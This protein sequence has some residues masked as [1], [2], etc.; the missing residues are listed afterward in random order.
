MLWAK[1][2]TTP[3]IQTLKLGRWQLI[4]HLDS[5]EPNWADFPRRPRNCSPRPSSSLSWDTKV[6]RSRVKGNKIIR[7][8]CP[9]NRKQPCHRCYHTPMAHL[10]LRVLWW[11]FQNRGDEAG[12]FFPFGNEIITN[13]SYEMA[14]HII[15]LS[16]ICLK[17]RWNRKRIVSISNHK[18]Q[19]YK[20]FYYFCR[21]NK[22]K[23]INEKT[24]T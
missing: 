23:S 9:F 6:I 7:P 18:E 3:R 1:R 21:L 2:N 10:E 12:E 20:D 24:R 5:K 22:E 15:P 19:P 14:N 13:T 16:N 17:I 11:R 4:F 8:Y